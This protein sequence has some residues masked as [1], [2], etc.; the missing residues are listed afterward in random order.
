[1]VLASVVVITLAF[2]AGISVVGL[3][4]STERVSS[5][6]IVVQPSPSPPPPSRPSRPSS[7][8]SS[9]PEST[10]EIN[11]YSDSACT[12]VKESVEWGEIEA[13]GS[14]SEVV[15]I[16]NSGDVGVVLSLSTDGWNPS[17]AADDLTLSWDYD[18][19]ILD[20][21]GVLEVTLSLAVESSS[22]GIDF[23]NFD[24]IIMCSEA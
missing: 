22:S 12:Q 4:Q 13:G 17:E 9:P 8:P 14:M 23:F 16:K 19:H 11:V 10:I 2:V 18:Y 1:M 24:I 5:S 21:G 6:G 3:I 15:Y 7:P 20:P